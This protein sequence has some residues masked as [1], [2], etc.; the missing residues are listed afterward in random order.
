M[1]FLKPILGDELYAQISE[2]MKG[3]SVKLADLSTG[4]Y[5]AK[6]KFDAKEAEAKAL[7]SQIADANKQIEA[8][9][10]MDIETV[11]K[12][13]DEY[14][15]KYET[16]T[17]E[18]KT[19]LEQI[20]FEAALSDAVKSAN[21]RN[22]KAITGLLDSSKLKL[23]DDGTISGLSEQLTALKASDAYL[24]AD[25]QEAQTQKQ[26]ERPKPPLITAKTV[27]G[28][29]QQAKPLSLGEALAAH[30]KPKE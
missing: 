7:S 10:A 18:H 16:A 29:D 8:F 9:K 25:A 19:A 23:N 24:F 11:K 12:T 6:E 21:G 13:A 2:K 17:A 1:E 5:V 14:K 28:A 20:R 30:F 26:T 22:P 27:E 4:A 15:A 3:S